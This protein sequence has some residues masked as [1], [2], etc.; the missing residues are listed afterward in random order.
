NL[1][2]RPKKR[3]LGLSEKYWNHPLIQQRRFFI[4]RKHFIA[5][6]N[7]AQNVIFS[8]SESLPK[9]SANHN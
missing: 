8:T 9:W 3:L 4:Q 7:R 2:P 6:L 1:S 5:R